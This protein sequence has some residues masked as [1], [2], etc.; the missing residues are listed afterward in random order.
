MKLMDILLEAKWDNVKS[1]MKQHF[2]D[3]SRKYFKEHHGK[4]PIP[5]FQVKSHG[6]RAGWFSASYVGDRKDGVITINPDFLDNERDFKGIIYHETIH[7]Y[8]FFTYSRAQYK[9]ASDGGHDSYFMDMMNKINAGEGNKLI[10]VQQEVGHIKKSATGS[11]WVYGIKTKNGDYAFA[12]TKRKNDKLID[13]I[14]SNMKYSDYTNPVAFET[15]EFKYKIGSV[16][17]DKVK[18]AIPIDQNIPDL[19]QYSIA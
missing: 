5:D 10:T 14:K 4:F 13:R 16:S 8:Q 1:Q 11:F 18:F 2:N 12:W 3:C 15:D 9:Y 17:G 7:Y 6:R 19:S